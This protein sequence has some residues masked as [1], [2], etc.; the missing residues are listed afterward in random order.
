[1]ADPAP[2]GRQLV[3]TCDGRPLASALSSSSLA[4][5]EPSARRGSVQRHHK[6]K[7]LQACEIR[8]SLDEPPPVHIDASA[9]LSRA[10]R[11]MPISIRCT[12]KDFIADANCRDACVLTTHSF[13]YCFCALQQPESEGIQAHLMR[14][15]AQHFARLS[16]A[17]RCDKDVFFV[18]FPPLLAHA[19]L[20]GLRTH[21]SLPKASA[22]FARSVFCHLVALLGGHMPPHLMQEHF[23]YAE[24]PPTVPGEHGAVHRRNPAVFSLPA[25]A[26][27]KRLYGGEVTFKPL[28]D[29]NVLKRSSKRLAEFETLRRQHNLETRLLKRVTEIRCREID[30]ARDYKLSLDPPTLADFTLDVVEG[31]KNVEA[32]LIRFK[33]EGRQQRLDGKPASPSPPKDGGLRKSP[34]RS[35]HTP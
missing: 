9:L 27:E 33:A 28:S 17:L 34:K 35:S 3:N 5:M 26:Q 4:G 1:M 12:R 21:N 14:L 16:F 25:S 13:W 6:P 7:T 23:N 19:V 11:N 32:D 29:P 30:A 2:P 15:M 24:R 8:F 22:T 10:T 31:R 20:Y 18:H